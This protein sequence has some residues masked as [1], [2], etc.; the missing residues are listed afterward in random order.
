MWSSV[1]RPAVPIRAVAYDGTRARERDADDPPPVP[2]IARSSR[3][4]IAAGTSQPQAAL[5]LVLS[6]ELEL[7]KDGGMDDCHVGDST[8]APA[9]GAG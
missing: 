7:S 3:I 8:G 9:G 5:E 6:V 1:A 4:S 2:R